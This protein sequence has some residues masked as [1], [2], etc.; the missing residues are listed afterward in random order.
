[1]EYI[2]FF[3][4]L[5]TSLKKNL[6]FHHHLRDVGN[7]R[8]NP[9]NPFSL[10]CSIASRWNEYLLIIKF[11]RNIQMKLLLYHHH[12]QENL[13]LSLRRMLTRKV[14]TSIFFTFRFFLRLPPSHQ[15]VCE[16]GLL[17]FVGTHLS[18]FLSPLLFTSFFSFF[19]SPTGICADG[20]LWKA[21]VGSRSRHFF[22]SFYLK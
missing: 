20:R 13:F 15:D 1:M 11:S 4:L 22:F 10:G 2:H 9:D 14:S 8:I 17:P 16:C 7:K 6:W 12:H 19:L 18:F 5:N 21:T 3:I